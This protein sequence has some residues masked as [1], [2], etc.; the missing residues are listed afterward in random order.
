MFNILL[1]LN[2]LFIYISIHYTTLVVDTLQFVIFTINKY[3]IAITLNF[4]NI[5][6]KMYGKAEN[7]KNI[8]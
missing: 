8:K 1:I 4:Q 6:Q 5:N 7:N 3:K 2:Q